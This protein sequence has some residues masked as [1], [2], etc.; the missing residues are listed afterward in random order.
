[1][2]DFKYFVGHFLF[3][4]LIF[5]QIKNHFQLCTICL[6]FFSKLLL[7]LDHVASKDIAANYSTLCRLFTVVNNWMTIFG[8]LDNIDYK[9]PILDK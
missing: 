8:P 7:R 5:F 4:M 6:K 2:K 3:I 9:F 1:M